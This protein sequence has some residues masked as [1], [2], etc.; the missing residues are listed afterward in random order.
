VQL[1]SPNATLSQARVSSK[2]PR[3]DV[4]RGDLHSKRMTNH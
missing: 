1:L 4:R 2:L 3:H